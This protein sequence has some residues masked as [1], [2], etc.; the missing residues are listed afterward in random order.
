MLVKYKT[1]T[2]NLDNILQFFIQNTGEH[3]IFTMY[4]VPSLQNTAMLKFKFTSEYS[5]N[6]NYE[7]LL[8][9]QKEDRKVAILEDVKDPNDPKIVEI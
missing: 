4:F 8:K 1:Q 3:G 5:M 7:F 6:Y 2:I 9:C